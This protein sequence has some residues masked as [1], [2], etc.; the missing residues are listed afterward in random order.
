MAIY[1]PHFTKKMHIHNIEK[2]KHKDFL[3]QNRKDPITGDLIVENDEVVFCASCKSVF[4]V[5]TWLYLD[6]KHCEQSKTL[7]T[8]PSSS[9]MNLKVEEH[10]LFY[11]PLPRSPKS[12]SR[13]PKYVKEKPWLH[14]QNEISKIQNFFHHPLVTS[15][16]VMAWTVGIILFFTSQSPLVIIAFLL[17][18]VLQIFEMLHNWYFGKRSTSVYKHFKSNTFYITNK[19]VGFSE[20]Y[21][22]N[23]YTLPLENINKIDVNE[24]GNMEFISCSIYYNM[25]GKER[26]LHFSFPQEIFQNLTSFVDSLKLAT[27]S[28][29]FPIHIKS[30]SRSMSSHIQR[31]ISEGNTNFKLE[32]L[33]IERL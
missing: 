29:Q 6:K 30:K 4:L 21:G 32:Q 8:F 3:S 12:Q 28:A 13:I 11:Q 31:L 16:K 15:L 18:F 25:K 26:K 10:I 24:W 17:T 14:K 33:E 1:F 20:S 5:D 9:A 27:G 23:Y 19:S 2:D 7:E 22:T